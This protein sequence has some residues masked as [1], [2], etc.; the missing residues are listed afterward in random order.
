MRAAASEIPQ[1]KTE[2]WIEEKA[3]ARRPGWTMFSKEK[4]P[5]SMARTGTGQRVKGIFVEIGCAV[6]FLIVSL[7]VP[8]LIYAAVICVAMYM[9]M[10]VCPM[11]R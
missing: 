7:A 3:R 4:G 5:E 8:L 11:P 6:L 1:R 2:A 9:A 10:C